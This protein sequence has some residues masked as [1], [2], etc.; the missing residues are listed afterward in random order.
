MRHS[1]THSIEQHEKNTFMPSCKASPNAVFCKKPSEFISDITQVSPDNRRKSKHSQSENGQP[2][3]LYQNAA[4][5]I[6]RGQKRPEGGKMKNT[7]EITPCTGCRGGLHCY[8]S[9][10]PCFCYFCGEYPGT[11][12]DIQPSEEKEE[13]EN[14]R[15]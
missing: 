4:A 14:N 13:D 12:P 15:H 1:K 10:S 5:D 7:K 11:G 8:N 6:W 9:A 3:A 2:V